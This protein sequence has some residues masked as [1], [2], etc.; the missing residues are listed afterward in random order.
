MNVYEWTS[1]NALKYVH[2]FLYL[3]L[4]NNLQISPFAYCLLSLQRAVT[5]I[6]LH[7]TVTIKNIND[8]WLLVG[9]YQY[10]SPFFFFF[11]N[12]A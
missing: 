6:Y 5:L 3:M 2:V 1:W 12:G 7:E 10:I 8:M 9:F 4:I 11:L